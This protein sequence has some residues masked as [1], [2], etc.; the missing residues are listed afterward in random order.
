MS[1]TNRESGT[2]IDEIGT[3]IYRISTPVPPNPGLPLGFTFNQFL[4]VDDEPLLFHTGQKKLFPLV[5][6]AVEAVLPVAKLRWISFGHHEPDEDGSLEAWLDA[7]PS[8]RPA[9]GLIGALVT[10]EETPAHPTRVLADAE[11]LE[12]G[13]RRFRWID[14]PHL[15]H[16]W[17]A[18]MMFETTTRTLFG[19]DLFTQ[20]GSEQPPVTE[21]DL[22]GPSEG[23][24]AAMDYY[25]SPKAAA[26]QLEKLAGTEPA[27]IACMHGSSYRGDGA[28]ALRDLAAALAK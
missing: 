3:R 22:V 19:G 15:P 8:A 24:R 27:L 9:R 2:R 7:A 16:G 28:A 6:E 20:A 13:E 26:L 18:G 25:A 23:M 17:D 1:I 11:I 5:R 21:G 4:V 14:T 10:L 12:T